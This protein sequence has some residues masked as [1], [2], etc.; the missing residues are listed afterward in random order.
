ITIFSPR[1]LGKTGLIFHLFHTLKKKEY[2]TIYL[3]IYSTENLNQFIH[4]LANAVIKSIV[5]RKEQFLE[6][7]LTIFK[8]LR[9]QVSIN[10][11]SGMPEVSL[12]LQDEKEKKTTLHEIFQLLETH[13]I[14]NIIAI[15]EFQQINKYP[16]KNTER[17]LRSHIQHLKNSQF[18]FS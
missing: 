6:K 7:A 11:L 5:S 17:I 16:E 13:K 4:E 2:N 1:R 9:P 12:L 3:D 18:I 10:E 14:P 15:D 8:N